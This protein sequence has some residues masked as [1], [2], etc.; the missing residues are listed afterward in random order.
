[1]SGKITLLDGAVGTSLWEKAEAHGWKKD[2]VW[3]FN[4]THPEIVTELHREYARA[5]AQIILANTFGANGPTVTHYPGF[6][7]ENVVK[8]AVRLAREAVA[9]TSARVALSIGPL[10][11]LM[12]PWGD[13]TEEET[14]AIYEEMIGHGMTEKPDC[15]LLQT[16]MDVE[17]MRVAASAAKQYHVPVFCAMTFEKRGKTMMGNSVEDVLDT[18]TPLGIDAVGMNCSLGPDLALP[19]IREFREKTDLP[20]LFKPNAGKPILAADGSVAS[21]YDETTFVREVAPALELVDYVGGCCGCNVS[22][23][24]ALRKYMDEQGL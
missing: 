9:G 7:V 15:I 20:L 10:S 17:M 23:T 22:Y 24:R 21:A 11:Q 2:P 6:T 4:I 14:Q 3:Q 12:E 1:M 16:F 8:T 13:L 5:G 19:V 18:L